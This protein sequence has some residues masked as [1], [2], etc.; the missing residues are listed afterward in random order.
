MS[1]AVIPAPRTAAWG[2]ALITLIRWNLAPLAMMLPLVIVLQSL[3]A[4]GMIVGFGFLIPGIDDATALFLATGTPTVLLLMVGLVIVP[5]GV[6][7][8]RSD[9]SFGYMRALPVP[10]PLML[11]ADLVVWLAVALPGIFIAMGVAMW[12]FGVTFAI[13]WPK[14]IV[15]ALLVTVMATSVGYALA[16]TFPPMVALTLTQVLIFFVM[17]FSP[18][19]FP[20]SQ[21][22]G[23]YQAVHQVLPFEPGAKLIRAGLASTTFDAGWAEFAVLAAWTLLG[24]LVSLRAL[25]ARR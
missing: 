25:T 10:R 12:R 21:L 11:V 18:I 2:S 6:S 5:Q 23:W 19:N 20:A 16:V 3:L 24:V 9:G 1:E 22:P 17:L 4:G 13:D 7:T 15:A 14:L 8:A